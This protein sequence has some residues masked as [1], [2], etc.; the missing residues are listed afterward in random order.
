MSENEKDSV[1]S[2]LFSRQDMKLRNIRFA[3]GS[4]EII[5]EP[6][7]RAAICSA[8]Q[9]RSDGLEASSWPKASRAMIDV[10][11]FLANI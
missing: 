5:G 2:C 4:D 7:F 10:N 9:Q 8:A 3:R 11:E 1:K 6:D